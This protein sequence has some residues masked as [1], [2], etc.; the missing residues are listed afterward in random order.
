MPG[1]WAA[2]CMRHGY[3]PL[4]RAGTG[5]AGDWFY[6]E[7]QF[8]R[9]SAAFLCVA[10]A[11]TRSAKQFEG[12]L[13]RYFETLLHD[14][15]TFSTICAGL[16]DG[17]GQSAVRALEGVSPRELTGEQQL[18]RLAQR[19]LLLKESEDFAR[20]RQETGQTGGWNWNCAHRGSFTSGHKQEGMSEVQRPK[21]KVRSPKSEV[22]SPKSKV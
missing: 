1:Y 15:P 3:G 21:S 10:N 9:A 12:L 2:A 4:G 20:G 8:A 18:D 7:L 6:R 16:R 14:N 17:E 22:R 19:S 5:L 11:M 13:A